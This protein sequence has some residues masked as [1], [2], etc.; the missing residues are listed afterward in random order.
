M[1]H[2]IVVRALIS[3]LGASFS[4]LRDA[5][6]VLA[7]SKRLIAPT[8]L[9]GIICF[10]GLLFHAGSS[11]YAQ[12]PASVPKSCNYAGGPACPAPPPPVSPWKWTVDPGYGYSLPNG[13]IHSSADVDYYFNLAFVRPGGFCSTTD[14]GSTEGS[15]A[16]WGDIPVYQNGILV[17]DSY[18]YTYNVVGW[19]G[20]G[21]TNSWNSLTYVLT[22]RTAY[23][24]V[25]TT[26]SYSTDPL[27]GPYC[28]PPTVNRLKVMGKPCK[29]TAANAGSGG[30]D[31]GDPVDVSDGN[32]YYS[33]TDYSGGGGEPLSL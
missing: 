13:M 21:C 28:E 26:L 22:Q 14:I 20:E 9:T 29:C 31:I 2:R 7:S 16:D 3:L 5:I 27:T 19:L 1:S 25:D 6:V 32:V 4:I 18:T 30:T 17:E 12:T 10:L 23:C 24:S 8:R 11:L 33:E 15:N